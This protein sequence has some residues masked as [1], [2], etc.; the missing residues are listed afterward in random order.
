MDVNSTTKGILIPRIT[1]TERD[2]IISPD[3]A[4]LIFNT[5]NNKFEVFKSTCSCWVGISDGG[6]GIAVENT[7]PKADNLNYTGLF[8]VGGTGKINYNYTDP[9]NDAEGTTTFI[10]DIATT[11][12]GSTRTTFSTGATTLTG[13]SVI[14]QNADAGKYVR[15]RLIPR[16]AT[17]LLNGIEYYGTW[18]LIEALASP[19]ASNVTTTGIAAQ[20][21]L[22]TG[23]YTFA[24]GTGVEN[25]LGSTYTW[26]SATSNK[27][28]S[29]ATMSF[30][31]GGVAHTNT[32]VPTISEVNKYVRFGVIAKDNASG[33]A[34]NNVYSN[35]IGLVT[36]AQEAPPICN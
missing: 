35:W 16:A 29:M 10:W 33:T 11:S 5:T 24:G 20:G 21:N 36:L 26:Q 32:I 8:K 30:P 25:T 31:N 19:Y 18:I 2:A 15:A 6:S 1:S 17:G 14:F 28:V 23:S 7:A 9:D 34:T 13:A 4:L 3:N 27:G 12:N 22:L